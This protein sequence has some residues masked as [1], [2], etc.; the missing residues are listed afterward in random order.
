MNV[1]TCGL[2]QHGRG[3]GA[4]L[5]AAPDGTVVRHPLRVGQLDG[6]GG[7]GGGFGRAA[8]VVPVDAGVRGEGRIAAG[9]WQQ[10][11]SCLPPLSC[12]LC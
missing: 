6:G 12:H 8:A 4:L 9:T 10:G 7:A 1:L 2:S 11:H 5:L 3:E